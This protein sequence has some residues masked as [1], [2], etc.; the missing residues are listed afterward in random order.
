MQKEDV[1]RK[2]CNFDAGVL[3]NILKSQ[4]RMVNGIT[5]CEAIT[6]EANVISQ[7]GSSCKTGS[8]KP[9]HRFRLFGHDL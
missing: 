5:F 3:C 4:Q 6:T 7:R 1:G 8:E 2:D 9:T